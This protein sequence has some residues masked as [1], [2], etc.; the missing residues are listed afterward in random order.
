[1]SD[2]DTIPGAPDRKIV[3]DDADMRH[4]FA[5]VVNVAATNEE[6]S[7]LFG[8]N[9]DWRSDVNEMHIKLT[10][11]MMLTPHAAKRLLIQLGR[12]VLSYEEKNGKISVP[13]SDASD[14]GNA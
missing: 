9:K 7:V 8:T 14:Q 3:W 6:V 4:T 1:M 11:R 12:A 10:D 13:G 5:N 2:T